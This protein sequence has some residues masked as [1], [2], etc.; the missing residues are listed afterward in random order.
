MQDGCSTWDNCLNIA[1]DSTGTRLTGE[2]ACRAWI[3]PPAVSSSTRELVSRL[4][5]RVGAQTSVLWV[6]FSMC[7]RRASTCT[8][9][10]DLRGKRRTSK[11]C[12]SAQSPSAAAATWLFACAESSSRSC[13]HGAWSFSIQSATCISSYSKRERFTQGAG[14]TGIFDITSEFFFQAVFDPSPPLLPYMVC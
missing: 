13:S 5:L 12:T 14:G 4:P 3:K 1:V 8:P 2:W 6:C 10:P 7:R 11:R 9:R